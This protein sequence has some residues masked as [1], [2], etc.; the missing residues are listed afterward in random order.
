MGPSVKDVHTRSV[1]NAEIV[2][3]DYIHADRVLS[4]EIDILDKQSQKLAAVSKMRTSA[5]Y[6]TL[7]PIDCFCPHLTEHP[8]QSPRDNGEGACK[9]W[10]SRRRL[11][12][13]EKVQNLGF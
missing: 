13:S 2:R 5:Y 11:V 9:K 10:S 7:P 1:H 12:K 3:C 4:I 8:P 6:Q